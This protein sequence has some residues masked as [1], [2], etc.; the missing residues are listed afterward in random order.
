L[1]DASERIR[2]DPKAAPRAKR[3]WAR[4]LPP[5]N[6]RTVA[7]AALAAMM[8]GIVVNAVAL[9]HGRPVELGLAP[10]PA[11]VAAIRPAPPPKPVAK[12]APAAVAEAAP[13]PPR[14]QP[15]PAAAPARPQKSPDAIA[16]FLRAQ[17]SD[18]RKLTLAAQGALAKLGFSVKAT[19][20]LD[21]ETRSALL[22]FEKSKHMPA[23][24]EVT[25]KLVHALKAAAAE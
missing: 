18:R 7:G 6:K 21:A 4:S 14:P 13:E 5:P 15:Q 20:A 3:G 24:T 11:A 19:G 8:I 9:Q 12:P 17:G 23:S 22:E 16:D 25:A 2:N 1:P 10:N